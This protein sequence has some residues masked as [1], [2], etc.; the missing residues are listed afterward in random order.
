MITQQRKREMARNALLESP[1]SADRKIARELGFHH[2][3]ISRIRAELISQRLIEQ[4]EV[5]RDRQGRLIKTAKIG[6]VQRKNK[7]SLVE[8]IIRLLKEASID[9]LIKVRSRLD[10]IIKEKKETLIDRRLEQALLYLAQR[11]DYAFSQDGQGFNGADAG[12][13]HWLADRVAD[14]KPLLQRHAQAGLQMIRKYIKQLERGGLSL[15][16]WE[17][18]ADQYPVDYAY[19]DEYKE[20]QSPERIELIGSKVAIFSPYDPAV[21]AKI[22]SIEPKGSFNR[23]DKG[24]YFPIAAAQ[25]LIEKFPE[26]EVDGMVFAAIAQ[27]EERARQARL[28]AELA[29]LEKASE[30][31]QLIAQAQLDNPLPCGWTLRDY[32]KEG[33]QWLL[34]HRKEGI[35]RGGILADHMGLGKTVTALAAAKA[36]VLQYGCPVFVICP[37]SL[38]EN[39][40][41]EAEKVGVGIE[42]FSNHYAKIPVPI[43]QGYVLIAD[44]AHSFQDAKSKRTEKFMALAKHDNCLAAWLLTGTP[45]KNGRPINLYPLLDAVQH[46]LVADKWA[47]LKTYCN[48][49]QKTVKSKTFWDL[50][51]ASHLNELATK[52]ED[53]MLRRTKD[54]VL[55]ELPP[56]TRV[57]KQAELEP[58][59]QKAYDTEIK[60][61]VQD[62]RDRAKRGEVNK[63]AEALVT[64]NIL[65]RVGSEY[66]VSAAAAVAEELLEQGQS[67]VLFTEFLESAHKLHEVLGGELL[68]GEAK[69]QERQAMV[70]RFQCGESKVFIGTIKAGGVGLTLTAAS[71]VI[72]VD[73]AWTP[74]DNEQAEDRCHRIGQSN[75][76]FALWLELGDIDSAIDTLI[77][78]KQQRIEL[79][80]AGKRKTLRGVGS[81]KE[82]AKELL[83]IL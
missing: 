75:S 45:I 33:V 65:R 49:H 59:Q 2:S 7:Q 19:I 55:K 15:P 74:G 14:K 54:Q 66:K 63:D 20:K 5:R 71:H 72:M 11:C 61:L 28:E 13:G 60:R 16:E 76:V 41:R 53:V 83:A 34:A 31:E 8:K 50:T 42:V 52:T 73:R 39:W 22:K 43:S 26:H 58:K 1:E 32:Q 10:E 81:P 46:P 64:L 36:M 48:A 37:V 4:V 82:L 68:T 21:V 29:A 79:V 30:I 18:I 9:E 23:S 57:F 77:A 38:Q 12:F 35:Y 27:A 80:L 56:K 47:Y 78:S 17:A 40:L 70:D 6:E 51:G 24:W 62:Y 67:V 3:F 25:T 69:P 44:E